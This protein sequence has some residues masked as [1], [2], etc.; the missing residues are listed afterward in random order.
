[1]PHGATSAQGHQ[2]ATEVIGKGGAKTEFLRSGVG[3]GTLGARV[4]LGFLSCGVGVADGGR[5]MAGFPYQWGFAGRDVTGFLRSGVGGGGGVGV[6]GGVGWGWEQYGAGFVGVL[7]GRYENG[8]FCAMVQNVEEGGRG[9]DMAG[10]LDA[11][12]N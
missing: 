8:L 7:V 11:A 2:L 3:C 4:G 12:V 10:I 6:G 5:G 1:M 9:R